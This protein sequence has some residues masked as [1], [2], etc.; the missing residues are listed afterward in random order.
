[1]MT[2]CVFSR[3]SFDL[4]FASPSSGG[5]LWEYNGDVFLQKTRFFSL[6]LGES[7]GNTMGMFLSR[8]H[9]FFFPPKTSLL[10]L[11]NREITDLEHLS[12]I[13]E[14]QLNVGLSGSTLILASTQDLDQLSQ[15][16]Y[17]FLSLGQSTFPFLLLLIVL[18]F[19]Y[20]FLERVSWKFPPLLT[21][22]E[23]Q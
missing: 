15:L 22:S 9:I 20:L 10:L 23:M 12:S 7:C 21:N 3:F 18:H 6:Y 14:Y 11:G 4:I 5:I 8:K 2:S 16:W 13:W 19:K 1:M 17:L